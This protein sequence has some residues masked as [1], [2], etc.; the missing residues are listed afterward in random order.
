MKGIEE[1]KNIS[2]LG[3]REIKIVDIDAFFKKIRANIYPATVQIVDAD[4]IAGKSHLLFAFIN[5]QKSFEQHRAISTN[6]EVET[7]LYAAGTRQIGKAIDII[8][9][10]LETSCIA[11]LIFASDEKEAAN[12]QLKLLKL[13]SG[14][15]DDSVLCV[16]EKDK[17]EHLQTAFGITQLELEAA[18]SPETSSNEALTWLIVERVS[19]VATKH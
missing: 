16:K 14:V 3:F 8:G 18:K 6:L 13:I 11:V 1:N 17:I 7:L 10:K 15:R 9:V 19:L 12:A 5:A 2:V 4:K